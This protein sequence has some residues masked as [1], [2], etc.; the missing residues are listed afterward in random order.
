M[1]LE[2]L[3]VLLVQSWVIPAAAMRAALRTAGYEPKLFRVDFEPALAAALTRSTYD[4]VVLDSVSTG[5]SRKTVETAM[6]GASA[7]VR[8]V[9]VDMTL[10]PGPILRSQ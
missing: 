2:P 5:L 9:C 4:V 3:R 6:R 8:L 10:T 7:G 1:A